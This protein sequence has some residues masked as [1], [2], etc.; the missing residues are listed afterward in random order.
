MSEMEKQ[1]EETTT[2]PAVAAASEEASAPE[3]EAQSPSPTPPVVEASAPASDLA[4]APSTEAVPDNGSTGQASANDDAAPESE[5]PSAA[6]QLPEDEL[7]FAELFALAE[8]SSKT[9]TKRSTGG[10]R[11]GKIVE[12]KVVGFSHDA[13]FVDMGG[14]AEGLIS[15]ADFFDADGKLSISE[16]DTIEARVISIDGGQVK[17]GK[18]VGADSA[19]NRDAVRLAF[20]SGQ[21]VEGKVTGTNKGGLE[22]EVGGLRAF[23]PISQIDLRFCNDSTQFLGQK[24]VFRISEFK[25][26]G[27]NVVI[28]R[29]AILEEERQKKADELVGKL[30][31]GQV[32]IGKV[33]TLKD[34]GAFVD[35][36]GLEGLVHVSEITYEHI[37]NPK[38]K[39]SLGEEMSVKILKIEDGKGGNKK[40]S[41]SIKALQGDPWAAAKAVLKNGQKVRGRV[42]RIQDFGAFV[43]IMPG[44][45]ALIHI[46]NMSN[47]RIKNPRDLVKE[48][49]EVEATIIALD[50]AKRRIG[51][52]LVKTRQE[53]A[54]ELGSGQVLDGTIEKIETFGLFVKLQSGARG[55]VPSAETGTTRGSDLN[56]EFKIGQELKVSV[57]DAE[58]KSGK[59]RLSIRRVAEAEERALY[60]NYMSD[61]KAEAGLGTFAD[62]FKN[63]KK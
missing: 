57:V 7:S 13:I 26:N 56:K 63:L 18:A 61:T 29:R 34:Y 19:K 45:D 28:S 33:T 16:G 51:L 21:P 11:P 41:L 53:L 32:M 52:S 20:E 9:Q 37:K 14:K 10:L 60:S 17:L 12:A 24:L 48:G 1:I 39:L 49:D 22:V 55:L 47:E 59:I 25:N 43:E 36:G 44:I 42:Q 2:K 5:E 3:P 54:G 31:V 35:I 27:R 23:C 38:E 4:A 40:I 15:K 6:P 62:L 8:K 50:W 30:E 46:S 58:K